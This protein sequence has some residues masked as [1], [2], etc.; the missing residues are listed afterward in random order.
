[1]SQWSA[2]CA[3]TGV[4]YSVSSKEMAWSPSRTWEPSRG[5]AEKGADP[6][7]VGAGAVPGILLH[8]AVD[9]GVREWGADMQWAEATVKEPGG[10]PRQQC[11]P[12]MNSANLIQEGADV[13]TKEGA[14][15]PAHQDAEEVKDQP[16]AEG[17]A[18][19]YI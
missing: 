9:P 17:G 11:I 4:I 6:G 8:W 2:G 15:R 3:K 1:M 10:T 14:Q 5:C 16:R 7:P 18:T 13:P 19:I 12:R